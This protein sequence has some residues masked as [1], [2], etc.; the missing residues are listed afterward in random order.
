MIDLLVF[1]VVSVRVVLKTFRSINDGVSPFASYRERVTH[2]TPLG[3]S[4]EGHNL[5]KK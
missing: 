2:Y 4:V 3:L 1:W 5:G